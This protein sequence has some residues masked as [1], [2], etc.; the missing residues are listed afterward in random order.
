MYEKLLIFALAELIFSLTPGPAVFLVISKSMRRG[1]W[2]G[3]VAAI[4]VIAVNIFYFLL[5][6]LGV[7]AALAATPTAFAILK[8]AG[9]AYLIWSAIGIAREM[10]S[11]NYRNEI[12][13]PENKIVRGVGLTDA[14]FSAI[15]VQVSSIKTIIIFL[16]IIPQFIDPSRSA[17]PQF[18]VLCIISI[19]V[20]LPVLLVYAFAA[21]SAAKRIQS[22]RF[23]M[24]LDGVSALVLLGIAGAVVLRA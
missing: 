9:A 16:S 23:R 18:V 1:F 17:P 4:G 19:L 21:Y 11:E 2:T 20:E 24:V 10:N 13:V 3:V 7:G 6:A 22:I 14:L 12:A 5:S 15:A 8:Y